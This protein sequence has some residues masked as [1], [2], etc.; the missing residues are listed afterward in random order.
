VVV[1]V[2]LLAYPL[3]FGP[4][5][6]AVDRGCLSATHA[7]NAFAPIIWLQ[8]KWGDSWIGAAVQRYAVLGARFDPRWTLMRVEDA[9]G[10]HPYKLGWRM[11]DNRPDVA[12]RSDTIVLDAAHSPGFTVEQLC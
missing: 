5:C 6:W 8:F 12:H 3:S 7:A 4:A 1:V 10:L 2:A 11:R 9:A